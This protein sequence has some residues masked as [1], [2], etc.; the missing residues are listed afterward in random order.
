MSSVK[1]KVEFTELLFHTK[2]F[3]VD[4]DDD[5]LEPGESVDDLD[6]GDWQ[7]ILDDQD[8]W[9]QIDAKERQ[10]AASMAPEYEVGKIEIVT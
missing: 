10:E 1:V 2:T 3:A 9:T 5:V 4:L 6:D 8:A 7:Q